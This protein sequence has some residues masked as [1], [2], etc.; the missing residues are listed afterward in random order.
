MY[1][2]KE[3]ILSHVIEFVSLHKHLFFI[4]QKNSLAN[5]EM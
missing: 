1:I 4:L 5:R 2:E 3:N